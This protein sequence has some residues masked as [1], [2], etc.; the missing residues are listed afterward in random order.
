MSVVVGGSSLSLLPWEKP[1]TIIRS[2]GI[3]LSI[4]LRITRLTEFSRYFRHFRN[5]LIDSALQNL[6]CCHGSQHAFFVF[7]CQYS[8]I[9]PG[10]IKPGCILSLANLFRCRVESE[11]MGL[12]GIRMPLFKVTGTEGLGKKDI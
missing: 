9:N 4:S 7:I 6:T 10:Q 8:S 12:P 1:P 5:A 3:P 11:R 2:L